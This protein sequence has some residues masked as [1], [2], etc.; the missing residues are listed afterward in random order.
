MENEEKRART[1]Q[2]KRLEEARRR[3]G[4]AEVLEGEPRTF[5]P[6]PEEGA[7]QPRRAA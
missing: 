4:V 6:A 3:W 5:T 2:E 7:A 1:L